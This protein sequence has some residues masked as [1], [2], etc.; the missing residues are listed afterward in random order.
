VEAT[1]AV[2]THCERSTVP[3]SVRYARI[4]RRVRVAPNAG[5][6]AVKVDPPRTGMS[7]EALDRLA[8]WGSASLI[9]VSCDPPTL[10]RDAARLAQHGFRLLTLEGLDLFP[11]TPH[12]ETIAAFARPDG[13]SARAIRPAASTTRQKCGTH[14]SAEFSGACP[15][16][17]RASGFSIASRAR[18]APSQKPQSPARSG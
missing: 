12:V 3:S 4:D 18:L 13:N 2:I 10:A 9:Y 6:R 8:A 1:S 5:A 17:E 15:E 11:N 16:T 7:G 14:R